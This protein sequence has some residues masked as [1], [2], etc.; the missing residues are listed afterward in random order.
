MESLFPKLAPGQASIYGKIS[1]STRSNPAS[2]IDQIKTQNI[3]IMVRGRRI[4]FNRKDPIFSLSKINET[5]CSN[6][7]CK[8]CEIEA[9]KAGVKIKFCEF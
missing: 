9:K 8:I 5:K 6:A 2:N 1:E 7:T 4:D 3:S